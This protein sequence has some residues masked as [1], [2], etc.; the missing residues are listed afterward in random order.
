M[1]AGENENVTFQANQISGASQAVRLWCMASLL[2]VGIFCLGLV[3]VTYLKTHVV[4]D[5]QVYESNLRSEVGLL[6]QLRAQKQ[7]LEQSCGDLTK[8]TRK[9]H[10]C[11]DLSC[12]SP[13]LFLKEVADLTPQGITL[14][15]LVCTTKALQITGQAHNM[16]QLTKF[17]HAL[18]QSALFVEP[19]LVDVHNEKNNTSVLFELRLLK[20]N[21]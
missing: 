5:L 20:G 1:Y 14:Q 10:R 6:D 11:A 13:Y 17:I 15:S 8:R 21:Q 12:S 16:R 19:K 3:A 2:F 4:N 18:G 7:S 9:V